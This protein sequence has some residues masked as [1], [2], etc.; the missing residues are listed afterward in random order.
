MKYQTIADKNIIIYFILIISLGFVVYFN[1]INS[2]FI[3]DDHLLVK[4]NLYIRN[5]PNIGKFFSG[6]I[7][8]DTNTKYFFYR[9]LQMVSYAI[10]YSLWKLDARGYHLVNIFLHISVAFAII[11]FINILYADIF[12]ACLTA[13]LFIVHP[14]HIESVSYISGLSDML[15]ALFI[16]ICLSLYIRSK[17]YAIIGLTYIAALLSRETGLIL[18]ALILIY[19]FAFKKKINFKHFLFI[20]EITFTY[21]LLRVIFL[22]PEIIYF[23]SIFQRVLGFFAAL[24]TYFR[25]LVFPL[26]LHMAYGL[27]TFSLINANVITG[28]L[29]FVFLLF[30]ALKKKKDNELIFF[31]IFWFL[32]ALLPVSNIYPINAYMSE[33][34]LYVPSIGFFLILAKG[35]V[36]LYK[37]KNFYPIA[38]ISIVTLL[39]IYSLLTIRQNEYWKDP[40]FFYK[41]TLKYAPHDL[42]LYI[43][44]GN[45]YADT[46]KFQ[47]A[48][49]WYK[50]AL[51]RAP[52]NWKLYL[53]LGAAYADM[54]R[55]QKA[56]RWYKKAL[57]INPD[58]ISVYNNLGVLYI[59][60]GKCKEAISS[61]RKALEINPD[62]ARAYFGLAEAYFYDKQYNLAIKYC[63]EAV[64][65]KYNVPKEFL[66][67]LN[68]YRK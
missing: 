67:M 63:D 30:Y 24:T 42:R 33:H 29:I 34:W 2:G 31:S 48:I 10:E 16:F 6:A 26:D 65:F 45:A 58:S 13:I 56:V 60:L 9:P 32:V 62:Y 66:D 14:V 23:T 27:K 52:N 3:W 21:I 49:Y 7:S 17:S 50:K 35:L 5:L 59:R 28:F 41:R 54:G 51:I 44:L 37:N 11:W 25:L 20:L 22:K 4:D 40:V 19:H 46:G 64:K 47:K 12:L 68:S 1:S 61:Y 36:C 53:N 55:L 57:K 8:T 38:I 39:T 43:N 18:P 15:G